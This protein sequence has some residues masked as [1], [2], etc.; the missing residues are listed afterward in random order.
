MNSKPGKTSKAIGDRRMRIVVAERN[1]FVISAL[2][3][4]L[5]CDGRFE[6]LSTVQSG[7]QFLDLADKGGFDV[8]VIG[9]AQ[10]A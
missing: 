10:A 2:R 3:E 9:L 1:P 5:E 8:A 7:R 4:M 6:L